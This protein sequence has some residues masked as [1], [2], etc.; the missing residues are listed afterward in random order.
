VSSAGQA[1]S[2]RYRTE[3][4]PSEDRASARAGFIS[5]YCMPDATRIFV[6]SYMNEI[7]AF[8]RTE[9][10]TRGGSPEMVQPSAVGETET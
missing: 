6:P 1:L 4:I 9:H 10:T 2:S 8:E 7:Y 3:T 5:E